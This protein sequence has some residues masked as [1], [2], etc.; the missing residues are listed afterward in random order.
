MVAV[1]TIKEKSRTYETI[2]NT[3]DF[4]RSGHNPDVL[5]NAHDHAK[6]RGHVVTVYTESVKIIRPKREGEK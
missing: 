3:C 4:M 1:K 6:A 2:C 5:R